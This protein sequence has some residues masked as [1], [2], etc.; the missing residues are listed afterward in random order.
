MKRI[1]LPIEKDLAKDLVAGEQVLLSGPVFTARDATHKLILEELKATGELPFGL[2]G[3]TIMYAGPSPAH[4]GRPLGS[5]GPTTSRRMD[6][7]TPAL[8]DAG[9]GATFGKG[10]RGLSVVEAIK[11]NKA[12]YFGAIGG[13]AA[14][15]GE[16]V[17]AAEVI[18]YPELGPEALIRL[19][20]EDF[21]AF[22]ALDSSGRDY[23]LEAPRNWRETMLGG[24][25]GAKKG[26]EATVGTDRTDK[27][28][29]LGAY[30]GTLIS[31]EGGEGAGKSTHI[32]TLARDLEEL[33]YQVV[34]VREPGGT[35]LGEEI[36]DILL[37][38][39]GAKISPLSELF[40]YEVARAE[41]IEEVI[42]PALKAA[43]VVLLDRFTDSTLAYQGFGRGINHE[44]VKS[45]N[46]AAAKGI[47]P[48]KT[49]LIDVPVEEG[50]KRA[51]SR[52]EPDRLESAGLDFHNRVRDGFLAIAAAEPARV[53]KIDGTK[54]KKQVYKELRVALFELFPLLDSN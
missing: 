53:A 23:Y 17:K 6:G 28:D 36:R 18:A 29:A 32:K 22:V 34:T 38:D 42:E 41:L 30:P 48:D 43:K 15:L 24:G 46:S 14:L 44:T 31:F 4:A 16:H 21:P 2:K 51:T 40:L 5:V 49:I 10:D 19:E 3:Q 45:L 20:L 25:A 33:G 9:L 52:Q 54:D 27:G 26:A 7:A 35:V 13:V 47:V 8:L 1:K 50:L 37:N 12:V 39:A 11:R